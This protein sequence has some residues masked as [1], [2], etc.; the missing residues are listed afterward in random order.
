MSYQII[1]FPNSDGEKSPE[2]LAIYTIGFKK[3]LN[4]K[5][6]VSSKK[7]YLTKRCLS[8]ISY[9]EHCFFL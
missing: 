6:V 5:N 2:S 4:R 1:I 9:F 8:Q 3:L 7:S